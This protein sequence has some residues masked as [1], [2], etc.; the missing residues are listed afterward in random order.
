MVTFIRTK[1]VTQ[2]PPDDV[3]ILVFLERKYNTSLI[4]NSLKRNNLVVTVYFKCVFIKRIYSFC[5]MI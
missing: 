1:V 5:N 4:K 2:E 3:F